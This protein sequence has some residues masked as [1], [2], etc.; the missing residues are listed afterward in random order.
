MAQ[1]ILVINI[2]KTWVEA[3]GWETYA[4]SDLGRVSSFSFA[5]PFA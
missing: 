4:D 3:M 1:R 2:A 5:L